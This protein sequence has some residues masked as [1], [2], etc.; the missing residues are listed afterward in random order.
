MRLRCGDQAFDV[1]VRPGAG[2][3]EVRVAGHA[4][5]FALEPAGPGVFVVRAG[6]SIS[7]LHLARDGRVVHLSWDGVAYAVLE[8]REAAGPAHRPERGAL[9]APMPGRVAAV[10]VAPG[11]R[12]VKGE[13]LVVVEAMK[14]ENALRAPADGVVRAVLVAAGDMV[15]PGRAVVEIE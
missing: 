3:L 12:V 15:A 7:T 10:K 6:T 9:E 13:E 14:M 8:E 11:Q 5:R 2:G 4:L 1:D